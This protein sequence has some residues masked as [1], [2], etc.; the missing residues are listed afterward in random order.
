ME[1]ICS[2]EP[3]WKDLEAEVPQKHITNIRVKALHLF[4]HDNPADVH[5]PPSLDYVVA[6]CLDIIN[7]IICFWKGDNPIIARLRTV[8][9]Q[10]K[11]EPIIAIKGAMALWYTSTVSIFER[12]IHQGVSSETDITTADDGTVI[13]TWNREYAA[14]RH[15]VG[16]LGLMAMLLTTE[17][18]L[19]PRDPKLKV[20]TIV[21]CA[22]TTI[23][24][25]AYMIS[26]RMPTYESW[27]F[28]L[29]ACPNN[30]GIRIF[31]RSAWR[32]AQRPVNAEGHS[33]GMEF[34]AHNNEMR[35]SKNGKYLLSKIGR[36]DWGR[37][38]FWHPGRKVPGSP[39]N[40]W[41]KNI[42]R[43]IFSKSPC[44]K[45]IQIVFRLPSSATLLT[46]V[47]GEYYSSLRVKFDQAS[48]PR[49]RPTNEEC[50]KQF[51]DFSSQTGGVYP[52]FS[53]SLEAATSVENILQEYLY[54]LP[55]VKKP[56]ADSRG[57]LTLPF[58]TTAIRALRFT[59]DPDEIEQNL[60]MMTFS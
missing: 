5:Q 33:P 29:S 23:I 2:F 41:I 44:I 26:S 59:E 51:H 47:F 3:L 13:A 4:L 18:W 40:K 36:G 53:P 52:Y 38:S 48:R 20:A 37:A 21:S 11:H 35:L 27:D 24:F 1:N 9:I 30:E 7:H 10:T 12:D 60:F 55:L 14:E 19:P 57:N 22:A 15:Y 54:N 56:I 45:N 16:N 6:T 49:S 42:C 46:S 50:K 28:A 31:L 17:T 32:L 8:A 43:P 25:A 39:W 58:L 34:G